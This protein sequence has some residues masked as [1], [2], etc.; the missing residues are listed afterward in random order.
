MPA[1]ATIPIK[2]RIKPNS[3]R[4]FIATKVLGTKQ[5][6]M[7]WG[8]TILLYGVLPQQFIANEAWVNHELQHVYQVHK[9]GKW[10]FLLRYLI[11]SFKHGYHHHPYEVNARKH[12]Q[13]ASF[14]QMIKFVYK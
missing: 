9:I 14:R 8:Y 4:A 10:H 12:E 13:D 2:V 6:A 5:V 3:K 7:V 11:L 1:H